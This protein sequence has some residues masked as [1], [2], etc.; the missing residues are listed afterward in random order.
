MV[1][2][3]AQEVGDLNHRFASAQE[4]LDLSLASQEDCVLN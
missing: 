1:D 2:S 4:D 3:L